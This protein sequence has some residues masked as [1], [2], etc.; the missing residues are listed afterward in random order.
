MAQ[1]RPESSAAA[2]IQA[3]AAT[4]SYMFLI[5]A[6]THVGARIQISLSVLVFYAVYENR[7]VW[8]Y[9]LAILLH[10]AVDAPAALKQAGVFK[11]VFALEGM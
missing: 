11:N 6:L 1:R 8:L 2:Q 7:R 9:P 10:A 5:T 4:P 3:L